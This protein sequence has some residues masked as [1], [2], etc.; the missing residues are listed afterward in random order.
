MSLLYVKMPS[1]NESITKNAKHSIRNVSIKI[2]I[3]LHTAK[4][5][6]M[7]DTLPIKP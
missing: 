4:I 6:E 1:Q 5:K 3:F 7:K 2:V